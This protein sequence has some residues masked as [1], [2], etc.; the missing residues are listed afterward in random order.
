V[1][2][3]KTEFQFNVFFKIFY[4]FFQDETISTKIVILFSI[5]KESTEVGDKVL[6]FSQSLN[7]LDLIEH[8][9]SKRDELGERWEKGT[10]LFFFPSG[11][12]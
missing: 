11:C 2:A 1:S 4:H 10:H 8:F 9:L 3:D 5:I 7:T 12:G 6:V